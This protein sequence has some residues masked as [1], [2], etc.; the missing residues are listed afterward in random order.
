MV[1]SDCI[2]CLGVISTVGEEQQL[3]LSRTD[4]D[5]Y[6]HVQQPNRRCFGFFDR[7]TNDVVRKEESLALR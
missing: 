2:G 1:N 3:L 7:T 6:T 4:L 5:G